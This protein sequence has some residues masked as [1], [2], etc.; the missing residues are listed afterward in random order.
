MPSRCLALLLALIGGCTLPGS[1][2]TLHVTIAP[3][4]EVCVQVAGH[5]PLCLSA[6]IQRLAAHPL[7]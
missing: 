6:L 5:A 7:F 4:A 3:R 1:P 2:L